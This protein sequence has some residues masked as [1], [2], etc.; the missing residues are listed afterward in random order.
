[1]VTV[2]ITVTHT[3]RIEKVITVTHDDIPEL[4]RRE[5]IQTSERELSENPLL[6]SDNIMSIFASGF[7]TTYL[8]HTD[9]EWGRTFAKGM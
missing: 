2:V 1:M 4:Q 6:F 7:H 5:K 8:S 3:G 9:K